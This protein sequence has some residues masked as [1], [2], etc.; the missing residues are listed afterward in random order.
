VTDLERFAAVLLS[1]WQ[2]EGGRPTAALTVAGLLDRTL[3]YR[4]ARRAL[5]L[6]SS[7]DYEALVLRLIGEEAGLVVTDP[8]EAAEMARSTLESKIPDLDVL[9]LLRSATLTFTDDAVSRLEGVRPLPAAARPEESMAAAA[10]ANGPAAARPD[11]DVLPMRR[12]PEPADHTSVATPRAPSEPP[13]AFLT[14]VAFTPPEDACWQCA[15]PLPTGRKANFCVECGADQ[16]QPQCFSC[17]ATVERQWKHCP[18]CG[19]VLARS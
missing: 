4:A 2:N 11:P 8:I 1:E 7:E 6:E 3:P 14:K 12:A 13:P 10:E 17:G 19:M 18:E 9:R 5:A 16:R 15:Q